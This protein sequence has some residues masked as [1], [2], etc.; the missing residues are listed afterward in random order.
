M[1][2]LEQVS[3]LVVYGAIAAFIVAMIAFAIDISARSDRR[4][5]G[6]APARRR[7]AG[8]GM[9]V[10][11]LATILLGIGVVTRGFAAGH[12]PWS[13]MY[14][15][16]I[17]FTFVS[18]V[19]FLVLSAR[20]DLR[21][22]GVLMTLGASVLLGIAVV[23]LYTRADGI[24]PILDHYWLAIHVPLAIGGVGVFGVAALIAVLQLMK[25]RAGAEPTSRL[26]H[27][28]ERL[29][30]VGS[31]ER[32]AH[33]FTAVGF[34]LWTFTIIAG[35]IWANSAWTRPWGW[36]AKEVWSF[37]IWVIFAAYL[38][39]RATRGWTGRRSAYL[40]L[41]GFIAILINLFVI[42]YFVPSKHSYALAEVVLPLLS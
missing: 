31:L 27:L 36:D 34:V 29:P 33:R 8:A 12:V 38:H 10:T 3:T 9:A 17:S 14:E 15:F 11:M 2:N 16:T 42:N 22:V 1:Q 20:R 23:V 30:S 6:N 25:D 37:V 21:D 19:I 18:L 26:G 39:A 7:A 35:A 40:I 5:G 4:E 41:T 13:N 24:A 28:T 32:L